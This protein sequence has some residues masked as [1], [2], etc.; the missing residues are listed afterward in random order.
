VVGVVVSG[1]GQNVNFAV[2]IARACL[3]IRRCD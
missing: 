1:G 2:P 3:E